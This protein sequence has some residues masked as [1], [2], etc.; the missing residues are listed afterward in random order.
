MKFFTLALVLVF[1][2]GSNVYANG[3]AEKTTVK[4]AKSKKVQNRGPAS[5]TDK[6]STVL[7]NLWEGNVQT[8]SDWK[9]EDSSVENKFVEVIKAEFK[10]KSE[11]P[12]NPIL[13]GRRELNNCMVLVDDVLVKRQVYQKDFYV[14]NN[15]AGTN[16][17]ADDTWAV[18]RGFDIRINRKLNV[19][20]FKNG[21]VVEDFR[22]DDSMKNLVEVLRV[23]CENDQCEVV[24]CKL[25]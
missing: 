8:D 11:D 12:E 1:V 23:H 16:I 14:V 20:R 6:I 18:G 17:N 15:P 22:F 5:V 9:D 25:D 4:V 7:H 21:G 10:R 19:V 2:A 24:K 13:Q 3:A